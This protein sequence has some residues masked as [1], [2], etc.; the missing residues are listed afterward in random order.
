MDEMS[1]MNSP[2]KI[3]FPLRGEWN[4]IVSPADKIPSHGT[5]R[6]ATRY[7]FD[8][9]QVDWDRFGRP[10]YRGGFLDYLFFGKPL[11]SYYAYGQDVYAPFD[12]TVVAVED[13]IPENAKTNLFSDLSKAYRIARSLDPDRDDI[14]AVTGNYIIIRLRESVYAAFCHLQTGSILVSIGQAVSK[15]DLIGKVGHS[16]NSTAPHLHFQLMDSAD[17]RIAN[18]LPVAFECFEVFRGGKWIQVEESVPGRVDRIRFL[19][20]S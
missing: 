5:N 17:M 4:A 13:G 7:A 19:K 10:A 9:I 2:V 11:P 8:F 15:G 20:P 6:L 3:E 14:R 18:G 1:E 16:G 12:G